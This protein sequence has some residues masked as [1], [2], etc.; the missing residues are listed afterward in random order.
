MVT[1]YEKWYGVPGFFYFFYMIFIYVLITK[2]W[3]AKNKI[4]K[5]SFISSN[6]FFK[7]IDFPIG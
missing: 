6:S 2:I 3:F 7:I 5:K 1:R 4:I